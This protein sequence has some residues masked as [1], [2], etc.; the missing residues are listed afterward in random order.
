MCVSS[1]VAHLGS[2]NH[3]RVCWKGMPDIMGSCCVQVNRVVR[4]AAL[5]FSQLEYVSLRR[6]VHLSNDALAC[7][8]MS[9]GAHLKVL[10]QLP[11][12]TTCHI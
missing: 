7:L 9:C 4:G 10:P 5:L 12:H 6:A 1:A 11:T 8:A 3:E 2:A